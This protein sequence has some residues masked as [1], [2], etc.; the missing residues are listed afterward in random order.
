MILKKRRRPSSGRQTR[1]VLTA[2]MVGLTL[3]VASNCNQTTD[4][5]SAAQPP[6]DGATSNQTA[7]ADRLRPTPKEMTSAQK[8]L[9]TANTMPF[10]PGVLETE[11]EDV[12]GKAF[13]LA[14]YRGKVVVL[15]LW[16][17]WCGPCRIEIPHLSSL[18]NQYGAKGVEVIG[19]TNEDPETEAEA[20]RTFAREM[21]INYRLGWA[22]DT[23]WAS[24]G[25]ANSIPQTFVIGRDGRPVR[26][27][28]GFTPQ[29]IP[30]GVSEHV[31]TPARVQKAIEQALAAEASGD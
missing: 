20:V 14:D 17:T 28:A 6:S 8:S 13:H 24:L 29:T 1:I 15:D 16:A 10:A 7:A 31:A 30:D 5:Q 21:K 22:S 11:I 18:K 23:L 19:L 27:F 4:N 9:Q 2:V 26:F 25:R 3:A 12:D